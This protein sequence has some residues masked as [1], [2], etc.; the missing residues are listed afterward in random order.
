MKSNLYFEVQVRIYNI[1]D[2]Y[3]WK[4]TLPI[5]Q[6]ENFLRTAADKNNPVGSKSFPSLLTIQCL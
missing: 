2:S 1:D 5:G 6:D 3:N 4:K